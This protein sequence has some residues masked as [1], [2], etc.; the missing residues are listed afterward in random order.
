MIKKIFTFGLLL[1]LLA[2]CNTSNAQEQEYP[3]YSFWSNWSV[4]GSLDL[5]KQGGHGWKY[6]HG[7][8]MGI[9]VIVEKELNHVWDYR[10]ALRF[11]SL[12]GQLSDGGTFDDY[13]SLITGVKFS[14]NDAIL[15]Y[16]VDRRSS[17]YLLAMAGLSFRRD[18]VTR[19]M[20]TE[21][22]PLS[23]V[24]ELGIGYSYRVCNH[25]TI[26]G[27]ISV[28]DHGAIH[29]PFKDELGLGRFIYSDVLFSIGYL[30]NF[31]PTKAD[32]ER[33]A[34]LS[35][36]KAHYETVDNE[37]VEANNKID[38]KDKQIKK[39]ENRVAQLEKELANVKPGNGAVADSLQRLINQ[40]KEDQ[41]TYYA[42]PFSV[43]FDVDQYTVKSSEMKKLEAIA[44]IMK[45]N[46]NTKFNLYGFCDKSGSDAYNQK[47]SEK[48]V[49]EV[50]RILVNK[51][52]INP[53]RL[54]TE[55]KGKRVSFGDVS[56]SINR[57]VSF[58][59]VIE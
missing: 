30:Y 47:L 49:N 2:V 38:N 41:M 9:N 53:D 59:R 22:S 5:M 1:G 13:S 6:D 48:R 40:I 44:R 18:E 35:Q 24:A 43:L 19:S 21:S 56:F 58:Y 31:G 51:Y 7:T 55:G 16:N 4:G 37:L 32:V 46:R 34:N 3:H 52:G 39:L 14:I 26:F 23:I 57:R 28:D 50:K 12:F 36:L 15:G 45:D 8:T 11:P 27:E 42:I 29:N 10:L 17:I 20:Q 54:T 25:G 33:L